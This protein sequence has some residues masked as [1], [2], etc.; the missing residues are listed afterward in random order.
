M[1][2][3]IRRVAFD[4]GAA[5]ESTDYWER[6]WASVDLEATHL[7][8]VTQPDALMSLL[9]RFVPESGIVVEAGSGASTHLAA[10]RSPGRRLVGVDLAG[11]ALRASA[12]VWPDLEMVEG[13]I[14]AMPLRSG[15]VDCVVSLGVVEHIEGGPGDALREHRRILKPDGVGLISVPTVNVVR[16]LKDRWH[17]DVRRRRTY[18]ARGRLVSNVDRPHDGSGPG[19]FHQYEFGRSSWHAALADAG[20]EV[21]SDH[22]HMVH[23][24]L[25]ELTFLAGR[26]TGDSSDAAGELPR[27]TPSDA[28]AVVRPRRG[29]DL[30]RVL[31]AERPVGPVEQVMCSA[32]QLVLGHMILTVVRPR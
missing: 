2:R 4:S 28:G 16:W 19:S 3:R 13:D 6:E 18:V 20:F 17:L 15:S 25:G 14:R 22:R 11:Q 26:G 31:L 23:A 10:L 1:S 24:G 8:H 29:D 7:S 5:G 30:R 12:G 9:E 27:P 21:V 32:S